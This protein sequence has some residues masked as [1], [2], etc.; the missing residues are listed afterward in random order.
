MKALRPKAWSLVAAP[1]LGGPGNL[2]R[3]GLSRR[4]RSVGVFPGTIS[5]S[6]FYECLP[7]NSQ[8]PHGVILTVRPKM[9]KSTGDE[10]K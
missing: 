4:R 1:I 9:M 5:C 2:R 6:Q 7:P 3:Q 8:L 10:G